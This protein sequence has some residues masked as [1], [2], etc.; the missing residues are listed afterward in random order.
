MDFLPPAGL[1]VIGAICGLF[2]VLVG[3][4]EGRRRER[5]RCAIIARMYY[6][7]RGLVIAEAI[8]SEL[9]S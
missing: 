3:F 1:Y 9:L 7:E 4:A 6:E 8:E 2:G 5:A